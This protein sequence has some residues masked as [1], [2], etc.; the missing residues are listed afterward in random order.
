MVWKKRKRTK[1]PTILDTTMK[2]I[3]E[4]S[5]EDLR[6]VLQNATNQTFDKKKRRS[7][8]W[9]D[10]KIQSLLKDKELNGDRTA[11]REEIRK[12]KGA[13]SRGFCCFRSIL[14]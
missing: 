2:D 4:G 14:C 8:D 7:Q 5:W 11:L 6:K 3:C 13:V 1:P 9:F 12:L 10:E